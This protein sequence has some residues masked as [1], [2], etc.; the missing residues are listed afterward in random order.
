MFSCRQAVRQ[1]FDLLER[2]LSLIQRVSRWCHLALCRHCRA[3]S[4]QVH[5]LLFVLKRSDNSVE[6]PLPCLSPEARTRI[7]ATIGDANRAN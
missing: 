4:R 6:I 1:T 7:A 3:H 2:R 5:G